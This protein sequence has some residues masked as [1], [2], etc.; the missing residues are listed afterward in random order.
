MM[1]DR[2]LDNLMTDF[3]T[4]TDVEGEDQF[5]QSV[6][7]SLPAEPKLAWVRDVFPAVALFIAMLGAWKIKILTPA[8]LLGLGSEGLAYLQSQWHMLTPTTV[9][10]VVA[11]AFLILCYYTY[12][13]FAEI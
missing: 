4:S 6:M 7:T 12:E 8:V 2:E 9:L 5:V 10:A 13:T 11:G 3:F 1:T